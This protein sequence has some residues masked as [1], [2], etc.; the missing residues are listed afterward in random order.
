MSTIEINSII[1]K[2][3]EINRRGLVGKLLINLFAIINFKFS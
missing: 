1:A 2:V 3:L